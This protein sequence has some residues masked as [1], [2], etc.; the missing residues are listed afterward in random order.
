MLEG[1]RDIPAVTER[2]LPVSRSDWKPGI[3]GNE[4]SIGVPEGDGLGAG[5]IGD[6]RN[7][8]D[9]K[10]AHIV[11]AAQVGTFKWRGNDAGISP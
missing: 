7:G 4:R 11:L 9:V 8:A 6:G 1:D 2:M 10:T 3:G 5:Q